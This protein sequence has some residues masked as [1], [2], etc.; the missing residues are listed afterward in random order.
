LSGFRVAST[1]VTFGYVTKR[2]VK[3]LIAAGCD[4]KLNPF[5][6]PLN[7][8]EIVNFAKDADVIILGNEHLSGTTL[9]RLKK[10]RLIARYGVGLDGLDLNEASM[11]N[12]LI[13]NAPASS[14]EETADY[15]LGLILDLMRHITPMATNLKKGIWEKKIGHSM[16]MKTLGIVGV[17][18]VGTAVARRASGFN[19]NVLGYDIQ[20]R[21]E[22]TIYGL[23]Y[24]TFH[25]LLR[26]SDIITIHM[27][28]NKN[29]QDMFKIQEFKMMKSSAILINTAR[30]KII[31]RSA[32]ISAINKK[33]IAGYATDVFDV[34]P[35]EAL[36]IYNKDNVLITPHVAGTTYESAIR[37]GDIIVDNIIAFKKGELPPDIISKENLYACMNSIPKE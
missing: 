31:K 7:E 1:S 28:L 10:L 3:R 26:Q 36:S 19:M 33:E 17:G 2:P 18:Q 14:R 15:T 4:V 6:R 23:I 21:T 32:L 8:K 11:R 9:R 30:D 35:P 34:E 5:G 27:P 20:Q 16:N 24:T 29:T 37:I 25:D 12:I 22:P 13:V